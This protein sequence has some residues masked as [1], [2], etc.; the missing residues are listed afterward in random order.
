MIPLKAIPPMMPRQSNL[1]V[2]HRSPHLPPPP[3]SLSATSRAATTAPSVMNEINALEAFARDTRVR[4]FSF[5][6]RFG[7]VAIHLNKM[8]QSNFCQT[9]SKCLTIRQCNIVLSQTAIGL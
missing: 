2:R 4:I 9:L 5:L 6:S 1:R 3:P 8:W 7:L